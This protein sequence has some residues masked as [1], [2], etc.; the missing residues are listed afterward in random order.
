VNAQ[1]IQQLRKAIAS[2]R[3]NVREQPASISCGILDG[4]IKKIQDEVLEKFRQE[5]PRYERLQSALEGGGVPLATLSVCGRGTREIRYTK[6]LAYFLDPRSLHGLG[7]GCLDAVFGPEVARKGIPRQQAVWHEA[8]VEAEYDLGKVAVGERTFGCTVDI[9]ISSP[10]V[11]ILVE[12]KIHAAESPPTS[13]R[14]LSQLQRYSCAF[15]QKFPLLQDRTLKFFLTPHEGASPKD[16]SWAPLTHEA[17]LRRLAG[18]LREPDLSQ[19]ARHNLRCLLWD[20]MGG[21]LDFRGFLRKR[22]AER[23]RSAL[24]DDRQY[25]ALRSWAAM[26]IPYLDVLLATME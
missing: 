26:Q 8:T 23:L 1:E 25:V 5:R 24:D 13:A 21:P 4:V 19:T 12:Q 22:L 9:F 20:L 14:G 6:L 10:A 18:I 2:I 3:K 16:E 17:V 15:G 7:A 11:A